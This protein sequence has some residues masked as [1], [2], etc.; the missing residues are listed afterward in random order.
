MVLSGT[1]LAVLQPVSGS[2]PTIYIYICMSIAL[3]MVS[4][5]VLLT[6]R[7]LLNTVLLIAQSVYNSTVITEKF[8]L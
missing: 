5:T 2:L 8:M 6:N 1:L 4:H 7:V 3:F